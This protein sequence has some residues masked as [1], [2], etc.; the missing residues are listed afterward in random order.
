MTHEE[1]FFIEYEKQLT[2]A[3][4]AHREYYTY[5]ID[6]VP[7][8]VAR[9]RAA[10]KAGTYN[11]DG[12]GFT[13]T[14]K[15]LG[16]KYTYAAINAYVKDGCRDTAC[17]HAS[18]PANV[19]V[20]AAS[21]VD[22][23]LDSK[24]RGE[25][26]KVVVG[27]KAPFDPSVTQPWDLFNCNVKPGFHASSEPIERDILHA[28]SL[29]VLWTQADTE[30]C[31]AQALIGRTDAAKEGTINGIKRDEN[32]GFLRRNQD[33]KNNAFGPGGTQEE[34]CDAVVERD[35]DAFVIIPLSG[36]AREWFSVHYGDHQHANGRFYFTSREE[37]II[38]AGRVSDVP[39]VLRKGY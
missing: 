17:K 6:D 13:R 33:G 38:L 26:F 24:E 16:I 32:A 21:E 8:V 27:F 35:G 18:N 20:G 9:M 29:G 1:I 39:L 23:A 3:V 19:T 5:P 10:V 15:A 22:F 34:T 7:V 12:I 11:K 36:I 2:Q 14:C 28:L 30:L 31:E 25:R 37:L 4:E